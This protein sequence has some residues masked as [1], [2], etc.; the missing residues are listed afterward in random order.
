MYRSFNELREAQPPNSSVKG[1]GLMGS[2]WF[3]FR[4][5]RRILRISACL[6]S[7]CVV[8]LLEVPRAWASQPLIKIT[9]PLATQNYTSDPVT[10]TLTLGPGADASRLT[11]VLNG[12]DVTARFSGCST[13][14]CSG[15]VSAA[16]GLI[17]GTSRIIASIGGPNDSI[18]SDRTRFSFQSGVGASASMPNA[19]PFSIFTDSASGYEKLKI[20][21]KVYPGALGTQ[22]GDGTQFVAEM[23]VFDCKTLDMA[24]LGET[25]IPDDAKFLKTAFENYNSNEIVVVFMFASKSYAT[26]PQGLDTTPIGGSQHIADNPTLPTYPYN[27]MVVGVPGSAPGSAYESYVY[28]HSTTLNPLNG[29]LVQDSAGNYNYHPVDYPEFAVSYTGGQP[30][31]SIGDL[32]K[33][34]FT[35]P[36]PYPTR[37]YTASTAHLA[38]PWM[39]IRA[40]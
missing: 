26:A 9:A 36:N 35:P 14:N 37:T 16:D 2:F 39:R 10:V 40:K 30:S 12:H 38:S 18:D 22:Q 34:P 31:I 23:F 17:A 6:L 19:V 5:L 15:V 13:A 3:A 33:L 7:L 24:Q 25:C 8:V 1:P 27:Y 20:G 4:G 11:V 29:L 32:D 21:N 28:A